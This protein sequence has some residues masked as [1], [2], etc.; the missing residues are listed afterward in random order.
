MTVQQALRQGASVEDLYSATGIDPWFLDQIALINQVA[1]DV[2]GAEELTEEIVRY[3]KEHG[4]SDVAD[5]PAAGLRR[6]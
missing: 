2:R 4:F 1:E 3:G 5:S 6:V